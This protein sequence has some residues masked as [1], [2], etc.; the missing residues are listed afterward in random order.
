VVFLLCQKIIH[1]YLLCK[2]AIKLNSRF[3]LWR[4]NKG[5]KEYKV[6][7]QIDKQGIKDISE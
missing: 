4:D 7:Q 5:K 3:S 2:N 1:P 6:A